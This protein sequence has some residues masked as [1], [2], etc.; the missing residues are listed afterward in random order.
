MLG[1]NDKGGE[2][3]KEDSR[4]RENDKMD[5]NDNGNGNDKMDGN[6]NFLLLILRDYSLNNSFLAPI[7]TNI[8]VKN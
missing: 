7:H 8:K 4:F 3:K 2:R 5:G 6:D 1:G